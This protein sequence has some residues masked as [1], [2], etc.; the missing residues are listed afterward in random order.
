[1][2]FPTVDRK[3]SKVPSRPA[4]SDLIREIKEPS[5]L[6]GEPNRA[7]IKGKLLAEKIGRVRGSSRESGT[8]GAA[9]AISHYREAQ[10][11][12]VFPFS[13]R[14]SSSRGV[15]VPGVPTPPRAP[16]FRGLSVSSGGVAD[17]IAA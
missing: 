5:R 11:L 12:A 7:P 16:P 15:F 3:E 17:N 14:R 2:K 8:I 9:L 1:M 4:A 10:T 13:T 6:S